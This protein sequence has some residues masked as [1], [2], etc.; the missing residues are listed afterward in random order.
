MKSVPITIG[1]AIITA[2]QLA[3][4]VYMVAVAA[5]EGGKLSSCIK[6]HPC[7]LCQL[8]SATPT[9]SP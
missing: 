5:M 4:G 6:G 1:F 3:L 9:D 8:S 7:S 2:S